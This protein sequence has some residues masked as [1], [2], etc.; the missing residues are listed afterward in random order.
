MTGVPEGSKGVWDG[1]GRC[2][3][4]GCKVACVSELY[5][6]SLQPHALHSVRWLVDYTDMQSAYANTSVIKSDHT[7][8]CDSHSV[9]K[10]V[11]EANIQK[12][13]TDLFVMTV[14]SLQW[15]LSLSRLLCCLM[16]LH[17]TTALLSHAW[18]WH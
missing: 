9:S 14:V 16:H 17:P 4:R 1:G 12:N 3:C 2:V 10:Y 18:T 6:T 7:S 5:S 13:C 11:I 8:T 15:Y